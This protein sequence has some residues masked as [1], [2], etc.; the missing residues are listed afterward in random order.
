MHVVS[1][2]AVYLLP[3]LEEIA[4]VVTNPILKTIHAENLKILCFH[5]HNTALNYR[6][7]VPLPDIGP[8]ENN[9]KAIA[10]GMKA[11]IDNLKTDPRFKDLTPSNMLIPLV[12]NAVKTSMSGTQGRMDG[13]S[14]KRVATKDTM[15]LDKEGQITKFG[16]ALKAIATLDP[17]FSYMFDILSIH[18]IEK[19][20]DDTAD[21]LAPL[22]QTDD[23]VALKRLTKTALAVIGTDVARSRKGYLTQEDV[24]L[25]WGW[26]YEEEF[27]LILTEEKQGS[28]GGSKDVVSLLDDDSDDNDAGAKK[29]KAPPPPPAYAGKGKGRAKV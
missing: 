10:C 14:L 27:L 26:D 4:E 9:V 18:E 25:G 21:A 24:Y 15:I 5:P 28:T 29:R 22:L 3:T 17:P 8:Y 16:K 19:A 20:V 2:D 23:M 12:V 11:Y 13:Y 1:V 7:G 6:Y